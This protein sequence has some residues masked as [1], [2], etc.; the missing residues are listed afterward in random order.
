MKLY[1]VSKTIHILLIAFARCKDSKFMH[2]LLC[3]LLECLADFQ[4]PGVAFAP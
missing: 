1:L 3:R 2:K 4:N